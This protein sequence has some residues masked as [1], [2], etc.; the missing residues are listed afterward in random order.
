MNR[1]TDVVRGRP[2]SPEAD[3]AILS[4]TLRL[5]TEHGYAGMSMEGVAAAAGVGK[6]TI[7]RRFP[8]KIELVSAALSSILTEAGPVPDS[9]NTRADLMQF[10]T[11][12]RDVFIQSRVYSIVGTLLVEEKRNPELFEILRQRAIFP[13]RN[14]LQQILERGVQRGEIR[15]GVNLDAAMEALVGSLYARH[16]L[17]L[18]E[19]TDWLESVVDVVWGGLASS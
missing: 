13:R 1:E 12:N 7:Y 11:L 4:A 19:T 9:G 8:Q 10:L 3:Q 17:G 6:T 15:T 18:P 16:I 14:Q 5:L 2:R